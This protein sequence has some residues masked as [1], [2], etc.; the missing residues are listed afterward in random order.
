[1]YDILTLCHAAVF[2]KNFWNCTT[3]TSPYMSPP[4]SSP[5]TSF[6]LHVAPKSGYGL[7]ESYKLLYSVV[8]GGAPA[9]D[10]FWDTIQ[11]VNTRQW[12]SET[13]AVHSFNCLSMH[14]WLR[15]FIQK[16][17][18][19]RLI[20]CGFKLTPTQI[21]RKSNWAIHLMQIHRQIIGWAKCIVAHLTNI[22]GGLWRVVA[23]PPHLIAPPPMTA[24]AP[25]T[26]SWQRQWK[27][28]N[29]NV[30]MSYFNFSS[31]SFAV[32]LY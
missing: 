16:S 24:R 3:L 29:H 30:P 31:R 14:L 28:G 20:D 18:L 23:Q 21:G 1:M 25:V 32:F 10:A 26:Q 22:L 5:P 11:A 4:L 7:R 2:K 27:G 9:T 17:I 8:Q 13:V 6:P 15:K 12:L 19:C